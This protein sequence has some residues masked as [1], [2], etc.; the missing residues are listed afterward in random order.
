MKSQVDQLTAEL[1]SNKVEINNILNKPPHPN[2]F[3]W[4]K[5]GSYLLRNNIV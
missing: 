4:I 3:R 2:N 5:T 1:N